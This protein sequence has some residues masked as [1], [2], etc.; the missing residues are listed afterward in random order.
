MKYF[1][2]PSTDAFTLQLTENDVIQLNHFFEAQVKLTKDR[3]RRRIPGWC[4]AIANMHNFLDIELKNIQRRVAQDRPDPPDPTEVQI[5]PWGGA[6]TQRIARVRN[7]TPQ[8]FVLR[9]SRAR[10]EP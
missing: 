3:D 9:G 5:S 8:R 4:P 1:K 10:L 2:C 7:G 6:T